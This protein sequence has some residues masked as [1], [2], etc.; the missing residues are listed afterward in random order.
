MNNGHLIVEEIHT[1][2]SSIDLFGLFRK[3]QHF[4]FLDSGM[5]RQKL[6]R[7]SFM[8]FAPF[9]TIRAKGSDI[10][11]ERAG[12]VSRL[13]GNP[14]Y[15][16]R[17]LLNKYR[18]DSPDSN[19]PFTCGA[20]GYF[21][22]DLCHHLE[23]VPS[24][25]ADDMDIAECDISFYDSGIIIDHLKEK[26][27]LAACDFAETGLS[28]KR[29]SAKMRLESI[30]KR[31]MDPGSGIDGSDIRDADCSEARIS[32]NF[33]KEEYMRSVNIAKEYI[34]AGDIYQVNLSQRF[35]CKLNMS[36][37]RLFVR[38][39][40]INPAPFS[41]YLDTGATKIVSASP[42]RFLC[43]RGR[44]IHTRP[45]KGTRP[46]GRDPVEDERLK[47]ELISSVKD[48]AEHLMIVDLERNDLG[49]ICEYGSIIPTEFT[50]PE[51]YSTVYHLAS[52]ISGILRKDVDAVDCLMNCF[53]GGS[54]TGAPK[55]RSMEIIDELEP[56]RRSIYTGSIGYIGFD[57]NMDTSI[58]IRTFIVKGDK[59][60]FHAGGGIVADSDPEM[61]YIET[62]DKARAL[63]ESLNI[64][65]EEQ[66]LGIGN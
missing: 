45:I 34:A 1:P 19:L 44:R 6:G 25:A 10:E 29:D 57:G 59:V 20:V 56:T 12:N 9:I 66:V 22:Y 30:R 32:S 17:T 11:I 50:I 26:T 40:Q 49:R 18:I 38:L 60:Y 64:K 23:V 55:I 14:F 61:E 53:P 13:N 35:S 7:F 3:E 27:Y 52:T 2:L 63:M 8:G 21:S 58:V 42:E 28:G 47:I 33:T 4:Y 48:R 24:R 41:A 15:V 31:I 5:D 37:E 39:R 65:E 36:P 46:R 16:L 62:L 43:K 54:I 51:T